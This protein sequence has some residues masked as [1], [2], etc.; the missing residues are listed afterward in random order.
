MGISRAIAGQMERSSWIRRM[1]EIG[2]QLRKERGAENVFDYTLGNPDVEPPEVVLAA[3]RRVVREGRPHSHGYMPNAGFPEV[4]SRLAAGLA[5][6]TGIPFRGDDLIMTNG[7]AGAINTVLKAVLDPGD[8][9]IVLN[10]Y[11]PE[12][13]FYIENHGGRVV[14]VETDARFQPDIARIAAAIT[15]RTKALLLNSPNNPTGAVYGAGVLRELNAI[16]REP[17]LVISD[18]PYRPL[19]YDGVRAP[20]IASLLERVVVTWSWSKAMAIAGERIGYLAIPPHLPEAGPLRNACTFANRILGYI[21]APAIWQW[22]VSEAPDATVD[23]SQYEAKRNLLC[24]ALSGM[25]YDAPRPQGSYYVF[26]RTPIPDD[27]EFIG[28][29]Q[30]E[31]IL[32]VPGQGFG[33]AGYMRLSLTIP[34]RDIEHSLAGFERAIQRCGVACSPAG[35]KC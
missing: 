30:E 24:D 16:V 4:R 2:I 31:G 21:N 5:A 25:G 10:P 22:V 35:L 19:V 32:A 1:F 20:E 6:R 27:V 13:R 34:R 33:R 28:M 26:P 3:L 9:V 29:L 12:Y 7:A 17:V 8:E 11:F 14:T 18:E 23:I 15:P